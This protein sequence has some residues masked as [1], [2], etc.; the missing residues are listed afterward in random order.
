MTSTPTVT[1]TV[2]TPVDND[3]LA[4][5]SALREKWMYLEEMKRQAAV[6]KK[7]IEK[8]EAFFAA[9]MLRLNA[10]GFT[11]DGIQRVRY[12]KTATF[13]GRKFQ[14]E[15][16]HFAAECMETRNVFS[17]EKA[18]QLFP[19]LYSAYVGMK[20]DYVKTPK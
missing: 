11:V 13:A 10:A 6:L 15:N 17:A 12:S 2:D 8:A 20:F 14:D 3:G 19:D 9:E 1:V 5:F 16:P 7:G 18:K 4:D